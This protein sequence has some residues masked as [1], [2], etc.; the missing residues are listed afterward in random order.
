MYIYIHMYIYIYIYTLYAYWFM[1]KLGTR[2]YLLYI[3]HRQYIP[4]ISRDSFHQPRILVLQVIAAV[5]R[6][7]GNTWRQA[8]SRMGSC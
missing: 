6:F 4:Q 3:S 8:T 7:A 5:L 2:C 1:R